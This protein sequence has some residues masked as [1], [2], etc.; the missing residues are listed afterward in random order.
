M[1]KRLV[2]LTGSLIVV[3]SDWVLGHVG[4]LLGRAATPRCVVL[5]YHSVPLA[6]RSLFVKQMDVLCR[7]ARPVHADIEILPKDRGHYVA[8]TFD[9]GLED[10]IDNALPELRMRGIPCT[11][12]II[13]EKL[14]CMRSWEHLV[15]RTPLK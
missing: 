4:R 10:I 5:A 1:L 11:V 12:F 9:D 15:A 13:T 6:Q 2:N 7:S 14:G 8:V 3:A